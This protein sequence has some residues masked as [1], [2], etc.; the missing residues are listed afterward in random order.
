VSDDNHFASEE[1]CEPAH[2][3]YVS[4][5]DWGSE[6]CSG[7]GKKLSCDDCAWFTACLTIGGCAKKINEAKAQSGAGE[8]TGKEKE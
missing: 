7:C 1:D 4:A 6:E 3:H 5:E 2:S 8:V